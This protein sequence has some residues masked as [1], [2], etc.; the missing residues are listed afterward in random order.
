MSRTAQR[1]LVTAVGGDKRVTQKA[2]TFK[3]NDTI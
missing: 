2:D 1:L 3:P